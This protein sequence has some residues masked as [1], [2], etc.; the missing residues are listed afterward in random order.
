MGLVLACALANRGRRVAVL[1]IGGST[2][3]IAGESAPPH[4]DR[5][6]Y[7]GATAGRAFGLGGTSVLWGGQLLPVRP[8][9][10]LARPQINALAWPVH[11]AQLEPHFTALQELLGVPVSS[12]ELDSIDGPGHAL[13]SLDFTEWQPRLSKWLAFGK[14]NMANALKRHLNQHTGIQIWLN[15]KVQNFAVSNATDHPTVVELVA[16]SPNGYALRVHPGALVIASGALESARCVLELDAQTGPLSTGV[17]EF[18]GRFLHDHLSLRIARVRIRDAH[19][20]E[21]RFA[22][23]F[24]GSTMRSLRMELPPETLRSENLP[25]LYAHFIAEAPVASGFAVLRDSLRAVQRRDL[26]LACQSAK[27]VPRAIPD[28]ARMLHARAV[29]RR[30]AFPQGSDFFLHIDL[31]QAPRRENRVYLGSSTGSNHPLHIDW[32][33]DEDAPRIARS[34]QRQFERFWQRNALD[35]IAQ[36]EFLDLTDDAQT[37]NHNVYDLYHPAGTTRMSSDPATG[38]VDE[39][40][41]IH[42]THNAYVV[43]SSVFPSMGAANPTFTAM[44]LALR[45]AQ[46]IDRV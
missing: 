5:R 11:Y 13:S 39:N 40:L 36:L 44:A 25:G 18:T 7:R 17:S 9:D 8:V 45:L 46:F 28:I 34:V 10:L 6:I 32:D 23:F 24:Q 29:K 38:V 15:A 37:W 3:C 27:R 1:E 14:R 43:G 20:F 22:P 42:G 12:F 21:E 19:G 33:V 16:K 41:R 31:E 26:R 35:R 2:P 30:L 4:F